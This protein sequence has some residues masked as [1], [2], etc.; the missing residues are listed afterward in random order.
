MKSNKRTPSYLLTPFNTKW[1]R[2]LKI[3]LKNL[4]LTFIQMISFYLYSETIRNNLHIYEKIT[5]EN[6]PAMT[7]AMHVIG[8]LDIGDVESAAALYDRSFV[9]YMRKPFYI[10]SEVLEA[11]EG[12]GNFITGA[13]GFLQSIINGYGG[14]RLYNDT[15]YIL[16]PRL[17]PKS[18]KLSFAG[19]TY[20]ESIFS[21]EVTASTSSITIKRL[22][23]I[24]LD[25]EVDGELKEACVGCIIELAAGKKFVMKAKEYAFGTC[26]LP[27]DQI[28]TFEYRGA[29]GS[30]KGFVALCA[31]LVILLRML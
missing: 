4:C 2:K 13:G 14:V 5:R 18:T 1:I 20:L 12:A 28:K 19:I 9:D 10:W 23:T 17:P 24:E 26:T 16:N 7:W 31:I 25:I 21:L 11:F 3:R 27:T 22:G 15:L 29:A 6:G 30:L 8:H